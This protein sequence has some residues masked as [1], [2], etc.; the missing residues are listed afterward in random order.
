[1]SEVVIIAEIVLFFNSVNFAIARRQL[2]RW[3]WPA[4]PWLV[5][6]SSGNP[7][8][9]PGYAAGKL[10][11]TAVIMWDNIVTH[12]VEIG[13][14]IFNGAYKVNYHEKGK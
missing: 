13:S 8:F 10:D 4:S 7:H 11:G 9:Q 6:R 3:W 12:R 14:Q 1:M 5:S 2:H